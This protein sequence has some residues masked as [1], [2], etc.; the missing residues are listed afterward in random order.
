MAEP[1]DASQIRI[2]GEPIGY[3]S[4][5]AIRLIFMREIEWAPPHQ[6]SSG[7]RRIED[8]E[9]KLHDLSQ[10]I[11]DEDHAKP[12]VAPLK[13]F[14]RDI[15]L[16]EEGVRRLPIVAA[17][18][19]PPNRKID[20]NIPNYAPLLRL[21]I[22]HKIWSDW[23]GERVETQIAEV[24][25]SEAKSSNEQSSPKLELICN[26]ADTMAFFG[27]GHVAYSISLLFRPDSFPR[28]DEDV[29]PD[30]PIFPGVILSLLDLARSDAQTSTRS[31]ITLGFVDD[32][33][34]LK[35]LEDFVRHRLRALANPAKENQ[36]VRAAPDIPAEQCDIFNGIIW[37]IRKSKQWTQPKCD[38]ETDFA[39]FKFSHLRSATCEIVQFTE[40]ERLHRYVT[41]A[42]DY[43]AKADSFGKGI[44]GLAQN[45]IDLDDQDDHE[46]SDS[47]SS[48]GTIGGYSHFISARSVVRFYQQSRSFDRMQHF[49][50]GDPYFYLT[51]LA[52]SYNEY[53]TNRAA[54]DLSRLNPGILIEASPLES[55][56]A[57]L[58]ARYKIFATRL[59]PMIPNLFRYNTEAALFD[60][61]HERRGIAHRRE[62]IEKELSRYETIAHDFEN[63][64][65]QR[66]NSQFNVLIVIL[67]LWSAFGALATAADLFVAL[68]ADPTSEKTKE[69]VVDLSKTFNERLMEISF[70]MAFVGLALAAGISLIYLLKG[71]KPIIKEFLAARDARRLQT[72]NIDD[73]EN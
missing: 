63:L 13:S 37:P 45:V 16:N 48:A 4:G 56:K 30:I 6:R 53:L 20:G 50:G 51:V 26:F 7:I 14:Y 29:R 68:H 72:F 27:Q 22:P 54:H 61:I 60:H 34:G 28:D 8:R 66:S 73:L 71:C 65:L 64:N 62:T 3:A 17:C 35:T 31:D 24:L 23:E 69:A 46:V 52:A 38:D 41:D 43:K 19:A 18:A 10:I 12:L 32:P 58:T 44:A 49:L 36:S 5:L 57:E 25:N 47:L 67:A 1:R 39:S 59:R 40:F 33:A 55:T 42:K 11:E 70:L 21:S 9:M 2:K 15:T